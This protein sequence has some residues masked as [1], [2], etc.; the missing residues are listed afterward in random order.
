[1][2]RCRL[3]RR[4]QH[5]AQVESVKEEAA[6]TEPVKEEAAKTE[7]AKEEAANPA[8]TRDDKPPSVQNNPL[9]DFSGMRLTNR[10]IRNN[11]LL[12]R[13]F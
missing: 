5:Q 13:N 4:A 3:K 1:M 8:V 11:P 6:K 12:R 7:P 10:S 9:H 2:H